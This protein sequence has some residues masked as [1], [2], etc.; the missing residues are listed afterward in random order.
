V[1]VKKRAAASETVT[2]RLPLSEKRALFALAEDDARTVTSWIRLQI[3]RGLAG[4]RGGKSNPCPRCGK[5][6]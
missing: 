6:H 5:V 3:R 4:R 1:T 2:I